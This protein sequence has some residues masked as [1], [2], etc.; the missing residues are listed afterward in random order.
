MV[1]I[2]I[3]QRL[4][5]EAEGLLGHLNSGSSRIYEITTSG[6][7][8]ERTSQLREFH[9]SLAQQ[10]ARALDLLRIGDTRGTE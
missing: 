3:L 9:E 10:L 8:V 4:R 7:I 1:V 2:D 6:S 5:T